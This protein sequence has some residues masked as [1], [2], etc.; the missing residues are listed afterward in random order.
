MSNDEKASWRG[1]AIAAA[2]CA[3]LGAA[4]AVFIFQRG[5]PAAP[6]GPAAVVMPT[7]AKPQMVRV[8]TFFSAIDYA[9]LMV[10]RSKGW[11]A[12]ET[13][14]PAA[15][16]EMTEFQT[17]PTINEAFAANRIDVVFEAE[18]PA[19][20]GRAAGIDIKITGIGATLNEG[21]LVRSTL[22]VKSIAQLKGHSV[23]V[24]SGTAMHFGLLSLLE[25]NGVDTATVQVLNML[26][27]DAAA[28]FASGQVD[29][30]AI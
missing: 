24:L 11:L 28:A 17:L 14:V 21:I 7:T 5:M 6:P 10:A 8:G 20:V 12:E 9:P 13:G 2:I 30:W 23:A 29:A 26:P 4:Y 25:A 16:I 18:V 22:P 1:P 15:N 3:V 19:I 27:P